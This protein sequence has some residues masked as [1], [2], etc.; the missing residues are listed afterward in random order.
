MTGL[1]E[2]VKSRTIAKGDA[3]RQVEEWLSAQPWNGRRLD[4]LIH[5]IRH[6][7]VK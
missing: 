5:W 7:K 4:A 6:R 3:I 1:R 2:Q